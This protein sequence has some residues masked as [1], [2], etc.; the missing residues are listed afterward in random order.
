LV[1]SADAYAPRDAKATD[2]MLNTPEAMTTWMLA[3]N[4]ML[5]KMKITREV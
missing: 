2:A 1:I 4:I 3:A 5:S